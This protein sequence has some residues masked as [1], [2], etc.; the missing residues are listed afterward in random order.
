MEA[1]GYVAHRIDGT[2]REDS[3]GA[4]G[5]EVG[6]DG[7]ASCT[8]LMVRAERDR[9]KRIKVLERVC[10]WFGMGSRGVEAAGETGV[11]S[12]EVRRTDSSIDE[13]PEPYEDGLAVYGKM[14]MDYG[15]R[16]GSARE[17][18]PEVWEDVRGAPHALCPAY[19]HYLTRRF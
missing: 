12:R 16:C 5:D 3:V 10:L 8:L 9:V 18:E 13:N 6:R 2:E 15:R 19:R 17:D 7:E 11:A 4:E 1:V 14:E